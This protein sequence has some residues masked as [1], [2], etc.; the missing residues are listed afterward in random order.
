MIKLHPSQQQLVDFASGHIAS[1]TGLVISAHIDMC[2]QCQARVSQ[3]QQQLAEQQLAESASL[4]AEY[5]TMLADITKL[6]AGDKATPAPGPEFLELDGRRFALPRPLRRY[7]GNTGNWSHLVSKL[8][9]APVDIGGAGKAHFIYMEKG[10]KVPEHTH[11]GSELTLVLNGQFSDGTHEYDSGDFIQLD[12]NHTHTP[13]SED[14]DGC[15]VF[16][17]VDKPLHFTSG[18]ARLI[19]PFSQLFFK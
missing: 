9:Q 11:K 5:A 18:L 3:M 10:G 4:G 1:A 16:A 8:W 19:N 2:S 14:E 15:L 6:P 13:H 17:V 7:I 12:G